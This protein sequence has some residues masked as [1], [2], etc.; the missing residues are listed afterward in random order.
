MLE[1]W[2]IINNPLSIIGGFNYLIKKNLREGH[3]DK[4]L[5]LTENVNDNIQRI[6]K[7]IKS[8]RI[9]SHGDEDSIKENVNF[10]EIADETIAFF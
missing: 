3:T 6:A 5:A 8:I 9:F 7:L 4:A 1:A 2:P 10:K